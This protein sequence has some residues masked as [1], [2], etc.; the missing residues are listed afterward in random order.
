MNRHDRRE[1]RLRG[2]IA[3]CRADNRPP[4]H[5]PDA[6]DG[7]CREGLIVVDGAI[8]FAVAAQV[9][10]VPPETVRRLLILVLAQELAAD[11]A[12]AL[13]SLVCARLSAW[14]RLRVLEVLGLL[15]ASRYVLPAFGEVARCWIGVRG[16]PVM[17]AVSEV[18]IV[19]LSP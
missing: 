13:A 1:A 18:P 5:E 11:R 16:P 15:K 19:T 14:A 7:T 12:A 2:C 6:C 4:V 3:Q 17:A 10:G 9:A 8:V